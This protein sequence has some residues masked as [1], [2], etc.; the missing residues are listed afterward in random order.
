MT[1]LLLVDSAWQVTIGRQKLV[2]A[3]EA[4][5]TAQGR[6]IELRQLQGLS[7]SEMD[8]LVYRELHAPASSSSHDADVEV[9]A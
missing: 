7:A 6:M 9:V 8:A 5:L 4:R 3:I 1:D 2:C